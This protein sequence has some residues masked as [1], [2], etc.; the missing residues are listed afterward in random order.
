MQ[1]KRVEVQND[2]RAE[3]AV[4]WQCFGKREGLGLFMMP[5]QGMDVTRLGTEYECEY[6]KSS[7][8]CTAEYSAAAEALALLKAS[9]NQMLVGTVLPPQL[10]PWELFSDSLLRFLSQS[11]CGVFESVW[12]VGQ[13]NFPSNIRWSRAAV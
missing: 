10:V 5:Y 11:F 7:S 13:C 4:L 12:M 6:Y 3:Q 2:D 1:I 9:C 8:Q